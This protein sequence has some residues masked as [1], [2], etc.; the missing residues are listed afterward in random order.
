VKDTNQ[1]VREKVQKLHGENSLVVLRLAH[2]SIQIVGY[3]ELALENFKAK[4]RFEIPG[5]EISQP[6]I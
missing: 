1:S 6:K 3:S 2:V 5:M 4:Y